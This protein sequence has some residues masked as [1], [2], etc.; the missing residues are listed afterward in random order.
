MSEITLASQRSPEFNFPANIRDPQAELGQLMSWL[1]WLAPQSPIFGSLA[2]SAL[3]HWLTFFL[4][5]RVL[6]C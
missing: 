3:S 5:T 4:G 2:Y 1:A 6:F